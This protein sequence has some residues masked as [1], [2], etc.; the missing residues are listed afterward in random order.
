MAN[1]KLLSIVNVMMTTKFRPSEADVRKTHRLLAR[2]AKTYPGCLES[3]SVEKDK[4]VYINFS[5]WT[6]KSMFFNWYNSSDRLYLKKEITEFLQD[7]N[8]KIFHYTGEI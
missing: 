5:V 1:A 3:H 4:D 7:E 6:S 2:A 8:C